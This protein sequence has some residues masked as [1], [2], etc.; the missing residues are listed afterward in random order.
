MLSSLYLNH[1]TW[2]VFLFEWSWYV[3]V[4]WNKLI[5]IVYSHDT[6]VCRVTHVGQGTSSC[7]TEA[8]LQGR[9]MGTRKFSGMYS[10][11]VTNI[12]GGCSSKLFVWNNG[13]DA[14][15]W[16]CFPFFLAT[17]FIRSDLFRA[18]LV[19]LC[20][21]SN[22]SLVDLSLLLC[23]ALL[24]KTTQ[25]SPSSSKL[26]WGMFIVRSC[27]SSSTKTAFV[28]TDLIFAFNSTVFLSIN[29]WSLSLKMKQSCNVCPMI[30]WYLQCFGL[31]TISP[32]AGLFDSGSIYH[33]IWSSIWKG[34]L[35][36]MGGTCKGIPIKSSN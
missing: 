24:S 16:G 32:S 14:F 27:I 30:R 18:C 33:V 20:V 23:M 22:P 26:S 3:N 10:F 34:S 13:W 28:A 4:L 8:M 11:S 6:I 9:T 7:M 17:P 35:G 29:S 36:R 19:G 25:A 5:S 21:C 1:T 12:G 15:I 2:T 31:S